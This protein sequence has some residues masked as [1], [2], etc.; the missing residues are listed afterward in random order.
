MDDRENEAYLEHERGS[1]GKTITHSKETVRSKREGLGF[2]SA[3]LGV[4]TI[5]PSNSSTVDNGC[6]HSSWYFVINATF[7]DK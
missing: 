7:L 6:T 4:F 3:H 5:L 2:L 1:H